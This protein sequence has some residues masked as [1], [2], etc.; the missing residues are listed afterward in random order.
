MSALIFRLNLEAD[1]A[2]A[3]S[4]A[5]P[6]RDE[7]LSLVTDRRG[8]RIAFGSSESAGVWSIWGSG[9]LLAHWSTATELHVII[10][11]AR[12]FGRPLKIV[13]SA[14]LLVDTAREPYGIDLLEGE[15]YRKVFGGQQEYDQSHA[16]PLR[17]EEAMRPAGT[18]Q[19]SPQHHEESFFARVGASYGWSCAFMGLAQLLLDGSQPEG[20]ALGLESPFRR[21]RGLP[22]DGIFVSR[23][24]GFAYR[25]GLLAI[26][27]EY[28]ILRR[29]ELDARLRIMLDILNPKAL[30]ML[31]GRPEDWPDMAALCRHRLRFGY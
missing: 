27:E 18:G 28:E 22:A 6:L 17:A 4:I 10:N 20:I 2:D 19:S 16:R 13:T 9:Q 8:E 7:V 31:P 21:L 24:I 12:T 23:S 30:V 11:E 5:M 14:G 25:Y 29:P 1:I 26:G 15:N 3:F